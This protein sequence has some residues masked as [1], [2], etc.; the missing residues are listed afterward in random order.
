MLGLF[1]STAGLTLRL[2]PP[3]RPRGMPQVIADFLQRTFPERV[4]SLVD[5]RDFVRR[6]ILLRQVRDALAKTTELVRVRCAAHIHAD[7]LMF[8]Y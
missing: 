7:H 4:S 5:G 2:L 8:A 6:R 3:R 1:R